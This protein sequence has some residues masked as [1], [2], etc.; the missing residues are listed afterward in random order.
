MKLRINIKSITLFL[1]LFSM[2][3]PTINLFG[4]EMPIVYLLTP[5]GML[6]LICVLFGWVKIPPITKPLIGLWVLILI[7]IIISAFYSTIDKLGN[8]TF[9]AD[10][11]QY[12]VR[13]IFLISFIVMAYKGKINKDKFIKYFL[14]TL[15]VGMGIGLLQWIPWPGREFFIR[16][17]PFRDGTLQLSQLNRPLFSLRLH[18]FAQFAT[19]N[20]GIASFSAIFAYSVKKYYGKYKRLS[21]ML[22]IF[23]IVNI[24]ASQARAGMLAF[25]FSI[26]LFYVVTIKYEK[27]SIKPTLKFIGILTMLILLTIYLYNDGNEF[28]IRNFNRWVRLLETGGGA[29]ATTQP[30]YFF[31]LMKTSDYILGLS[32]PIINRSAI[33]HGI[34]VEPLNIFVTYGLTG[35]LLQYSLVL[36]LLV[37]FFR[38]ISKSVEDKGVLTLLITSFVGLFSYQVFS[39][40]YFF[41]REIRVGLFPWVLMGVSIGLYERY[42]ILKQ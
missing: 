22:L 15:T 42:K 37:Y 3:F 14:I 4:F 35:F 18:G 8:F 2:I 40:G 1:V 36:I 17:Y 38:R 23:S 33:S 10:I 29:R 24:I 30:E 16:L 25:V 39:V 34:E 41:Y 13:F 12:V 27:K 11:A 26:F 28:V 20:G 21:L 6:I 31:S 32:K 5:V 7:Q 9:P 19:A